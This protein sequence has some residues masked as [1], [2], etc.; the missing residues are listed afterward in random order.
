MQEL[1]SQHPDK[2]VQAW[3]EHPRLYT[4]LRMLGYDD[5]SQVLQK[6]DSERIGDFW[7]PLPSATHI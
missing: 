4:L 3:T 5:D 1:L 6:F 7:L 2:P